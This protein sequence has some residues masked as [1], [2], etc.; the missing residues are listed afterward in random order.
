MKTIF[1]ILLFHSIFC[2][3]LWAQEDS[4]SVVDDSTDILFHDDKADTLT[5][6]MDSQEVEDIHPQDSPEE[7]GFLIKTDDGKS[8]LRIRGSVRLHGVFDLNGLQNQN[9]F[10]VYDIPVGDANTTEPRFSM[11]VN[12]TRIGMEAL[13]WTPLGDIFIRIEGLY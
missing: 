12:Q 2:L 1:L 9:L 10:S 4:T 8:E 11:S 13:R 5:T 7:R 6:S 3:S